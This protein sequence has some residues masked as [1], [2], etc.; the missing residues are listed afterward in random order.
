MIPYPGE[1]LWSPTCWTLATIRD[2]FITLS[3]EWPGGEPPVL[4]SWLDEQEQPLGSSS[5]SLAVYL[6]QAQED[7]AGREFTCRG[8]HPL[9]APDP[10]CRLRL[11]ES[12]LEAWFWGGGGEAA[13]WN[14]GE[15]LWVLAAEQKCKVSQDPVSPPCPGTQFLM[16]KIRGLGLGLCC[17]IKM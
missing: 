8:T 7:L 2:Q 3:C 13:L 15:G 9:R 10:L 1:L 11:G 4:P 16:H 14:Q 5:S 12:E 6:L 17:P